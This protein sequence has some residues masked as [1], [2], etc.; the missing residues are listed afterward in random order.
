MRARLTRSTI[1][2][3]ALYLGALSLLAV[4]ADHIEQY[5]VDNYSTVPTIGTLFLLNFI[6]AV[7]VAAG[8]LAPLGRLAGRY[9]DAIRAGLALAG[10]GIAIGSLV[11]LFV[12]ES[13]A[14]FGFMET[15]YRTP[16]VVAIVAE[17]AATVFLAIF[18][19][20][21]GLRGIHPHRQPA[22]A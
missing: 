22:H 13:T 5:Y 1:A 21:G 19:A 4:G 17:A 3:L 10:I 11:A 7:V 14:L 20:A 12:S 8:L 16:I 9:S 18:L 6:G 2:R 15:G